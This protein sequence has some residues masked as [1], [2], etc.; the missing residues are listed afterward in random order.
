MSF[1]LDLIN[2][3]SRFQN[4]ENNG[5]QASRPISTGQLNGLPRL[6]LR[7]INLVISQG[8]SV[9]PKAEGRPHLEEGFALICFQRFSFP[10][11]ATQRCSWRNN[12]YTRGPSIPVLSY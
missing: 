3:V 12:W 7:P 11:I 5:G 4:E 8:P 9:R 1:N 2:G 10:D 6:H